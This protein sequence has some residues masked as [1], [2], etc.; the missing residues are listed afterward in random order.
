MKKKIFLVV[1]IVLILIA[2]L[3]IL[4]GCG[5]NENTESI[6]NNSEN[7]ES[8]NDGS[9]ENNNFI[10]KQRISILLKEQ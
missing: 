10:M 4:T 9:M 8:V 2:G 6:S 3:F 5:N 1:L 7:K